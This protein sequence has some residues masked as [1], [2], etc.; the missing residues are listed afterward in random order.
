MSVAWLQVWCTPDTEKL[1]TRLSQACRRDA[2]QSWPKLL[3]IFSSQKL[4]DYQ[5]LSIC[6]HPAVVY[7]SNLSPIPIASLQYLFSSEFS[8]EWSIM[9][10][11]FNS[12][13]IVRYA[14]NLNI[15]LA[16]E[17][18]K[19]CTQIVWLGLTVEATMTQSSAPKTFNMFIL[20]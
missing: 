12:Q 13:C 4:W 8:F 10:R 19:C 11:T 18:L 9:I 5:P 16:Q 2:Q 6:L 17:A 20:T 15:K 3:E 14:A 1:W 7:L